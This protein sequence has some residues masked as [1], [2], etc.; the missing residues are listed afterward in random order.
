[1][2]I[3]ALMKDVWRDVRAQGKRTENRPS[4]DT[5]IGFFAL[6]KPHIRR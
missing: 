1:M 4:V 3:K 2:E 5:L 6:R